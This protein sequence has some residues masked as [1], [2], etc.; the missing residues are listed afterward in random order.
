M[1]CDDSEHG[2]GGF[3]RYPGFYRGADSSV[4]TP[5]T[6][7]APQAAGII[8]EIVT[9]AFAHDPVWSWVFPKRASQQQYW[10]MFIRG[11]LRYPHV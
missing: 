7:A 6:S 10:R 5:V 9:D 2:A 4:I 1:N 8:T 3:I 11:A